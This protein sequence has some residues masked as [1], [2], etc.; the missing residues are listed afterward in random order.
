ML[1]ACAT[2]PPPPAPPPPPPPPPPVVQAVPYRPVPPPQAAYQMDLPRKDALGVR[3]TL[4]TG[5]DETAALWNFRSGWN[6]AALNCTRPEHAAILTGYSQ[7]LRAE[8][9]ALAAA[10]TALDTHYRDAARAERRAQ[11]L[12]TGATEVNRAAIRNREAQSTATYNYFASPPARHVF[13]D[14]AT[15]VA[16]DYL[17]ERP[18]NFAQFA[19]SGLQRYEAGFEQ[20]FTAYEAYETAS[21]DW[22]ARY[23][24]Q[25][26][27][28]QPGWVAIYG[29][30]S[31]QRAM[32][33]A[34]N[35]LLPDDPVAVPDSMTGTLI[36]VIPVDDSASGQPVV[37]PLPNNG[38][39]R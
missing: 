13:C 32:G 25:Y 35:S 10:N 21:R 7:M 16:N 15:Q 31:Q 4:N 34:V 6:V 33:V 8:Q 30:P 23:G 20:F 22:D 37:Q 27:A 17:A 9:R 14:V 1:A 36:P 5:L 26:G 29:T 38:G 3:Q 2:T 24:A 18:G 12:S 39:N 28:S 11:G 19:V